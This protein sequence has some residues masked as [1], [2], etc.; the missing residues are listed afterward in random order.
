MHIQHVNTDTVHS[1]QLHI[2]F[3]VLSDILTFL[4]VQHLHSHSDGAA[5]LH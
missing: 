3:P 2:R 5:I 4:L 1:V